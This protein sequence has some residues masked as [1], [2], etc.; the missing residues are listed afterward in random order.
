MF[1][2]FMNTDSSILHRRYFKT[3]AALFSQLGLPSTLQRHEN[4]ALEAAL[5]TGAIWIRQ[6]C[7]LLWS[8]DDDVTIIRW[9]PRPSFP[10]TQTQNNRWWKR[11][12]ISPT[13]W[14]K[15]SD[16][17]SNCFL[18]SFGIELC[19]FVFSLSTFPEPLTSVVLNSCEF[20][21]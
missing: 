15:T 18:V 21:W 12:E 17:F 3:R 16:M 8:K 7:V 14:R 11:F 5:Q 1:Y 2:I 10:Q 9:F 13:Q 4:G 6:F 19:H 20:R